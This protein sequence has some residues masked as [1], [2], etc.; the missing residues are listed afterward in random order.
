MICST[1]VEAIHIELSNEGI[2]FTVP[3]VLRQHNLLKLVDIFDDKLGARGSPVGNFGKFII[4][5]DLGSTLRI[6][7][8]LAMKP[9]TSEA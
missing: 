6:S 1:F 7:K 5:S 2:Y 8:V 3:K 4:L 9:A